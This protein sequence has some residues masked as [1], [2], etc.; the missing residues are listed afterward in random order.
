MCGLRFEYIQF[1]LSNIFELNNFEKNGTSTWS[2]YTRRREFFDREHFAVFI[3]P[4]L[5]WPSVVA[6]DFQC[7]FIFWHLL[8]TAPTILIL[9]SAVSFFGF[10]SLDPFH[11]LYRFDTNN[12]NEDSLKCLSFTWM[13]RRILRQWQQWVEWVTTRQAEA[14]LGKGG[15]AGFG[16]I[17]PTPVHPSLYKTANYDANLTNTVLLSS[18]QITSSYHNLQNITSFWGL[19]PQ[20]SNHRLCP[21][22]R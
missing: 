10:V 7:L 17:T 8:V 9:V 13:H 15:L 19:V 6:F 12:F 3:L 2:V 21:E 1:V 4:V 5:Q 11:C 22:N 20:T 18:M 16:R 14:D